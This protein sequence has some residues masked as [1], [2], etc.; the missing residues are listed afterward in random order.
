MIKAGE[1]VSGVV[2]DLMKICSGFANG[3]WEVKFMKKHKSTITRGAK[4][5]Q[6]QQ[7]SLADDSQNSS[8]SRPASSGITGPIWRPEN[9]YLEREPNLREPSYGI[10]GAGKAIRKVLDQVR[11]VAPTN[12]TV[13]ICGE[14]GVGKE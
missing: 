8:L 14:T 3:Q 6:K 7:K 5:S 12:S 1:Q 9:E 4:F 2:H 10:V 11:L 13:L